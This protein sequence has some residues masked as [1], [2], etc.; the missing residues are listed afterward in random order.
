M[1]R[2]DLAILGMAFW[3]FSLVNFTASSYLIC[4]SNLWLPHQ[5][6]IYQ[7][8]TQEVACP[9]WWISF[10]SYFLHYRLCLM[11]QLRHQC[12][13]NCFQQKAR[14]YQRG[15]G[16]GW[17]FCRWRSPGWGRHNLNRWHKFFPEYE[18]P[19]SL[20]DNDHLL[21]GPRVLLRHLC[22]KIVQHLVDPLLGTCSRL[23]AHHVQNQWLF[24]LL[25]REASK[26]R[27]DGSVP[28]NK[29][30]PSLSFENQL[31]QILITF[32][33]SL[34]V[35]EWNPKKTQR[36]KTDLS[37]E[38]AWW[39]EINYN[40]YVSYICSQ[41]TLI[42]RPYILS[43]DK[44]PTIY[45]ILTLILGG[46]EYSWVGWVLAMQIWGP[47]LDLKH[48][49][50]KGKSWVCHKASSAQEEAGATPGLC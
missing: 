6:P 12:I 25:Q 24:Q 22:K 28:R 37:I 19:D 42:L 33:R 9:G 43:Y 41:C 46:G 17:E 27:A 13:L 8:P 10:P 45:L 40:E 36:S 21:W 30:Q 26:A 2:Q 5:I 44:Q 29:P 32:Y 38:Q 50:Q 31:W 16:L 23:W 7:F 48:P 1:S 14:Y 18:S 4:V 3:S 11:Y 15:N 49:H 47:E 34:R 35:D 39:M 20:K